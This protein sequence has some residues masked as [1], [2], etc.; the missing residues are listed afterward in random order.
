MAFWLNSYYI[1]VLAWAMYYSWSSLGADV[2]WRTCAN[3]WNTEYCL[4]ESSLTAKRLRCHNDSIAYYDDCQL[5]R[6]NFTNPV[7]EYWFRQVLQKSA[8]LGDF[9]EIRWP[10]AITLAIAWIACYFCIWKGVRWTGKVINQLFYYLIALLDNGL[11]F[12]NA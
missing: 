1:V 9:G 11:A 7:K 5:I 2:P 12:A 8:G 10:L 4:E 6:S 3:S